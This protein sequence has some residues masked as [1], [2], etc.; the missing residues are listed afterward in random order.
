[1]LWPRIEPEYQREIDGIVAGMK[2]CGKGADRW[3]IVTLNALE[4][5]PYYYVP[6]L[7]KKEGKKP[8]GLCRGIAAPSSPPV[9][10]PRAGRS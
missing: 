5:M 4:E 2:S 7:D 10:I 6:W 3:D 9:H 8:V 1:M